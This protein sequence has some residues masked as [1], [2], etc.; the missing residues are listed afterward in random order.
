MLNA[1]VAV[2]VGVT[3]LAWGTA[4]VTAIGLLRHRR[5]DI[6]LGRL[7]VS[8]HLFFKRDTFGPEATVLWRRLVTCFVVFMCTVIALAAVAIMMAAPPT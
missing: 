3:V 7:A 8:G 5:S 6:S 4:A 1:I 2:L